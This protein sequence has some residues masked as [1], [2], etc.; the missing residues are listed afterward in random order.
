MITIET[1]SNPYVECILIKNITEFLVVQSD[2]SADGL[3]QVFIRTPD[4]VV[5]TVGVELSDTI[6]NVKAKIQYT[7]Q[8]P[9]DQNRLIYKGRQLE[10][11]RTLS[12]Y[13]IT[14]NDILDLLVRLRG[15]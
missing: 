5:I 2:F 14:Y 3:K 15:G 7:T 8:L 4:G 13:G 10:D 11:G 9:P 12:D 6:D 1:K